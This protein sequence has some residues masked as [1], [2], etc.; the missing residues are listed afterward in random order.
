MASSRLN[1]NAAQVRR[2]DR[3]RY[4]TALFAPAARRE[5]L[6]TLY[7][8]NLE[9]AK[10]AEV[11][12]EAMIG[13]IRLQWW[14]EAL[15]EIYA[16]RPRR[17]GVIEPLA[18]AVERH[19]LPRAPFE[20]LIDA[21]ETDLDG[22]PPADL[23]ALEVYAEGTAGSLFELAFRVLDGPADETA[24]CLGLAW[25]LTGLVRAVPFHAG[26]SRCYLPVD[27]AQEA[28][29]DMAELFALRAS[30][31]LAQVIEGLAARAGEHLAALRAL[32]RDVPRSAASLL[33]FATLAEAHLKRLRQA[34]FDPFD[35]SLQAERPGIVWRLAWAYWLRQY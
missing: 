6:F 34:G 21:R 30:P 29:L 27:L 12:S 18:A 10:T 14:R 31:A 33:L 15:A 20:R 4:L 22:E 35:S 7:A 28:G 23:T 26:Q 3:E 2:Q 19:G 9:V 5:D 8:F 16:G 13:R 32:C 1:A 17:H 11:V 24:R 25:A